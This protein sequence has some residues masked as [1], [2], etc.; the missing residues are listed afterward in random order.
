[1]SLA[2][3]RGTLHQRAQMLSAVRRFFSDRKILEVDTPLL[4][5]FA[6]VDAYIDVMRVEMG[7]G[8]IGYLHTSPEYA[9][10]KLL[11]GGAGDIYQL[12]HVFRADEE[13]PLHTP[14]FTMIEWYRI[15]MSL[16]ALIEEVLELIHLFVG[17]L[18]HQILTYSEVFHCYSDLDPHRDELTPHVVKLHPEAPSWDRDTQLHLLFSHLIEPNMEPRSLTVVTEFPATQAALAKTEEV[19]GIGI[20]KRFEVYLGGIELANGFDELCDPFEQQRRLDQ[21]NQKREALGKERLP[22][23]REFVECLRSLPECVG[24][25]VGFDRLMKLSS[26]P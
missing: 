20:A 21:E 25:A 14:E 11:A 18:P 23:D 16:D 4:S 10:K 19:D 17:K 9:M 12:S 8:K 26:R 13:G 7:R 1:M 6:P 22:E 5:Q 2:F 24:V 15:G 3:N